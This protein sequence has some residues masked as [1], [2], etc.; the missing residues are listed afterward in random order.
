[1]IF[2]NTDRPHSL[3]FLLI[4]KIFDEILTPT[5]VENPGIERGIIT[6]GRMLF[7]FVFG[8]DL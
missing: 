2:P 7:R 5:L 8:I 4:S 6:V 1:M 3:I